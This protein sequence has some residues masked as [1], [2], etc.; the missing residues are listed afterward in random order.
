MK[1]KKFRSFLVLLVFGFLV[2]RVLVFGFLVSEFLGFLVS[3][4]QKS[5]KVFKRYVAQ[6]TKCPSHVFDRY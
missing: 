1:I 6:I 2:E 3:K 5:F 4:I